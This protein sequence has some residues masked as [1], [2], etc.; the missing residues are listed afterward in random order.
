[1]PE[2]KYFLIGDLF[3][4]VLVGALAALCCVW[5]IDTDWA[6]LPAFPQQKPVLR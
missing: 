3:A 1:M 5:L 4:N 6:M 2:N